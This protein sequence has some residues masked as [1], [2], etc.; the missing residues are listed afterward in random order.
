[1]THEIR[2]RHVARVNPGTPQFDEL[3]ESSE[4]TFLP[5]EAVWPGHRLD[6]TNI[7]IKGDVKTGY[8][9]FAEGDI[10]LPKITPTFEGD[11][12]TIV[13]GLR[14]GVGAGT[15]ELHVIRPS[16]R[17]DAR[18][19]SYLLSSK[20]FLHG[21]EV[22]MTGVA[23]QKRVPETWVENFPIPVT[24]VR[25]QSDIADKLDVATAEIDEVL[26]AAEQLLERL[27]QSLSATIETLI[28]DAATQHLPL[29]R[30][31]SE[32]P[33][34]GATESGFPH[35]EGW[36][37][38]IR[39]T[40]LSSD[41]SLR[42]HNARYLPPELADAYML[43]DMDLL[44]ARSGA[45]VGKAFLYRTSHGPACFAG[46]LIRFRIHSRTFLPEIAEAWTQTKH[47]WDQLRTAGTQATIENV[48]AS[49]YK[50][51]IV[52]I[53]H[54]AKQV[55]IADELASIR[56]RTSATLANTVQE[57]NLLRERRRAQVTAHVYGQL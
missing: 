39:I 17:I 28:L 33:R 53:V 4:L 52:P 29:R 18:Y 11:R 37:R 36:P 7:R 45:T 6:T 46:Y 57:I 23:G 9:R 19:L 13:T 50:S 42:P 30:I 24:D 26:T 35:N 32:P 1:M 14:D 12:S 47:Y 49:Q 31:L 43:S 51:L 5:L 38:Y 48:N 8:T 20:P 27:T 56:R 2:L 3:D 15:T 21:G 34:Y 44:V 25:R 16:D 40:D 10:L 41:G 54:P 55:A 22:A